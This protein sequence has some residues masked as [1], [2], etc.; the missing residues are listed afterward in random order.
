MTAPPTAAQGNVITSL[1]AKKLIRAGVYTMFLKC[2]YLCVKAEGASE[3]L[4][5]VSCDSHILARTDL[6]EVGGE[7]NVEPLMSCKAK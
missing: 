2:A 6:T 5:V 7:F 1:K 3:R 4:P